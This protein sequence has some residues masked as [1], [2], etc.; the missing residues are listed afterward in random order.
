MPLRG[1]AGETHEVPDDYGG[2]ARRLGASLAG[3][4]QPGAKPVVFTVKVLFHF[5]SDRTIF[6]DFLNSVINQ[7]FF[8]EYSF[9]SIYLDKTHI[10]P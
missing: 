6:D 10:K 1:G 4:V 7:L 2:H 3:V 8:S 5:L 9:D